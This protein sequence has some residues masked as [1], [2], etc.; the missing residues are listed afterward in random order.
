MKLNYDCLRMILSEIEKFQSIDENLAY[1]HMTLD[2]MIRSI[3]NFSKNDIV[4]VTLKAKEAGLINAIIINAD[5]RI[6]ICNYTS[7]TFEGHQFLDNIRKNDIWE[8]TKSIAKE[9]GCTSV[10][11]LISISEKVV[12]TIIQSQL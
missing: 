2:D 8:K 10:K 5:D 9:I 12:S 6:Y 3:P 1:Q 11:S 7:L 4:Y